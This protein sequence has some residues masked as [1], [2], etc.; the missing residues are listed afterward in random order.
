MEKAIR[1]NRRKEMAKRLNAICPICNGST[2][3]GG[4]CNDCDF[5]WEFDQRSEKQKFVDEWAR[6]KMAGSS[7]NEKADFLRHNT[8]GREVNYSPYISE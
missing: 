4:E 5:D 8:M 7:K 6:L 1:M 3:A 2:D